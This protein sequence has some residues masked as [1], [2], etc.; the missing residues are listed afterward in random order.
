MKFHIIEAIE[1]GI[2]L[3]DDWDYRRLLELL[4][5]SAL[6]FQDILTFYINKGKLSSNLEI[7]EAAEDF[8]EKLIDA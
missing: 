5:E 4:F 1:I 8:N 7:C 6:E 2:N 3:E